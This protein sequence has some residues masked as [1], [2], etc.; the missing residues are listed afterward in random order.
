MNNLYLQT[1]IALA[2]SLV[3]SLALIPIVILASIKLNL[4][5]KPN[6]RKVHQKPISRLGGVA[7]FF[8]ALAG[9]SV[10][11]GGVAVHSQWPVLFSSLGLLFLV[12]VRDDIK[13]ISA[14]LRFIIQIGL[15]TLLASTGIRL[16]S[17]YGVL[18][19]HELGIIWQYI[20]TVLLIVGSTNAFNLIDGVDGLAGG[21][22]LIGLTVLGY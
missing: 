17:L 8:S 10:S 16:T 6:A 3:V 21:L 11:R 1:G 2:V 4:V 20:I 15:A 13:E 9:I 18:G 22:S 19:V 14:R 7:I 5:D 12:G